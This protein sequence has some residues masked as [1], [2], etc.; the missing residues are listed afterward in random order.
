MGAD[1]P[2]VQ[3]RQ[4]SWKTNANNFYASD[5]WQKARYRALQACG[6]KCLCCGA[7]AIDGAVLHVD[8]IK[9][10][11]YFPHLQLE[12]TNLQVLCSDCNLG[13]GASDETDWRTDAQKEALK[14]P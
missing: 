2:P 4:T 11:Y 6:A 7:S 5:A 10:R 3:S 13:K 9:P 1:L 8:H 14:T 12:L